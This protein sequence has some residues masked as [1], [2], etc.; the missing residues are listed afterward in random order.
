M[1]GGMEGRE[2]GIEAGGR[3][4]REMRGDGGDKKDIK[5]L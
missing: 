3:E 1:N 4:E 2:E 5:I